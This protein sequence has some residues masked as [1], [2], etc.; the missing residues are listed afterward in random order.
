MTAPYA[1]LVELARRQRTLVQEG[2]FTELEDVARDWARLAERLPA[3]PPREAEPYLREADGLVRSAAAALAHAL[4]DAR[5][6]LDHLARG[7]RAVAG[8]GAPARS[9]LERVG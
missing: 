5:T 1:R 2:R 3:R 7:R 6:S 4:G 8:Y 9:A